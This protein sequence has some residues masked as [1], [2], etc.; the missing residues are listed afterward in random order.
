MTD[1]WK[2][3]NDIYDAH[4]EEWEVRAD[5]KVEALGVE[6]AVR[7]SLGERRNDDHP[8]Y[9]WKW[10]RVQRNVSTMRELAEAILAACDSVERSNPIWAKK[11]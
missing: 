5:L 8:V 3:W 1:A 2:Q 9:K 6:R 11:I 4:Y 7:L 10:K